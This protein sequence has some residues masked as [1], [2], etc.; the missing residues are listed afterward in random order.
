MNKANMLPLIIGILLSLLCVMLIP[1][2]ARAQEAPCSA[3]SFNISKIILCVPDD[4]YCK[5]CL[6]FETGKNMRINVLQNFAKELEGSSKDVIICFYD[7]DHVELLKSSRYD[8]Y[9]WGPHVNDN[10]LLFLSNMMKSGIYEIRV[11]VRMGQKEFVK[12]ISFNVKNPKESHPEA[13]KEIKYIE[14]LETPSAP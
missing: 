4:P 2:A 13:D 7:P 12:S 5:P 3:G 9:V 14:K 6:F 10:F 1:T 8:T 11:V